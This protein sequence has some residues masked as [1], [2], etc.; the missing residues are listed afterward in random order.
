MSAGDASSR[1]NTE[2]GFVL[3]VDES[4]W[5]PVGVEWLWVKLVPAGF[6]IL[7]APFFVKG[8]SVSDV[9]VVE[10]DSGGIV[11][12]WHHVTRSARTT[13]WI[14]TVDGYDVSRTLEA[15]RRLGCNTATVSSL[16]CHSVD[17]PPGVPISDVDAVLS[18]LDAK[19]APIAFPSFRHGEGNAV[20]AEY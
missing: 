16:R 7:S 17:V 4:G 12:G 20:T 3:E 8:L 2:L 18:Q 19:R 9:V 15:L 1:G 13:I 6:E 14:T 5:P 10:S 11:V